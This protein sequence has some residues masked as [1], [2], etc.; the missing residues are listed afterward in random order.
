[1]NNELSRRALIQLS[2]MASV[3]ALLP[4]GILAQSRAKNEKTLVLIELHGGND[5]LN[6]VI[7]YMQ[8]E[9]YANRPNIHIPKKDQIKLTSDIALHPSLKPLLD[10][11]KDESLA[12]VSGL[13]YPEPNRSHFRSIEI[14]DTGSS[15]DEYL[16]S[17]WLAKPRLDISANTMADAIVIGRNAA[18][19]LSAS[20][21]TIVINSV[22]K[23]YRQ[24]KKMDRVDAV[25]TNESLRHLLRTQSD[26]NKMSD[27]LKSKLSRQKISIPE[28]KGGTFGRQMRE[29]AKLMLLGNAAP[30]IKVSIGGFDT[31]QNQQKIQA[32]LLKQLA[33]GVTSFQTF[34]QKAGLWNN[35]MLMTYSEFGRR[36]KENSSGGTDHGTAAPHFI[37]GGNVKGGYYGSQPLLS[38][39]DNGDLK[40]TTDYRRVYQTVLTDWFGMKSSTEFNSLAFIN[41]QS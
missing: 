39:L 4:S 8:E 22:D 28:F 26:I 3:T 15:S 41:G 36:V 14:W 5:G 24:A 23:F 25:S 13:G 1:M 30:V 31:H 29:V 32:Q 21:R 16:Q 18:P 34:I 38:D 40:F 17:G 35:V 20:N 9:Y 7:P 33:D 12:I 37:L 6:T 10:L 11:T 2:S 19:V 27:V